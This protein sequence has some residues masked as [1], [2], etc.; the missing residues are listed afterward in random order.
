MVDVV[1]VVVDDVVEV[2]DVLVVVVVVIVDDVVDPVD[3][4]VKPVEG[5]LASILCA[6]GGAGHEMKTLMRTNN[7]RPPIRAGMN[8]L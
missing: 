1:D 8:V 6:C 4:V 5:G 3:E 2:V 7:E